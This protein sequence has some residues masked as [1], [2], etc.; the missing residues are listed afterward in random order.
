LT[1]AIDSTRG[2]SVNSLQRRCVVDIAAARAVLARYMLP[3][4]PEQA[5]I[6]NAFGRTLAQ[7]LASDAS[8]PPRDEA[9]KTGYAVIASDTACATRESPRRLS[10][11]STASTFSK[12]IEPGTV[13]PVREGEPLPEGADA[14]VATADCYRP[15]QGPEVLVFIETEPGANVVPAGSRLPAGEVLLRQGCVVGPVEMEILAMLGR[16][17]VAVRRKP[18][19]GVLTTGAGV[20]D[21][22]EDVKPG[23]SRNAARYALIGMLLDS[24]CDLGRLIHVRECRVGLERALA[25]CAGCDAVIVALASNDKHD[26]ALEALS[27]VGTR[28]FDRVQ[29]APGGACAFGIACDTPVFIIDSA[30]V[31]EVFEAIVRP[32]LM[33]MLGREPIDRPRLRA[34]LN[35]TL[36]LNPGYAHFIRAHTLFE[37]QRCVAKPV[38]TQSA[39]TN[40]LIV[41]EQNVEI[42]KRGEGVDVILL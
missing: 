9:A 40:S 7:D 3:V 28:C 17:G 15:E 23:Q 32:G 16:H 35:S 14:V 2:S 1:P 4:E 38:T 22:L 5:G 19:I 39:E 30:S 41:V 6:I 11:L 10:V 26:A 24:G 27:S 33:M 31:I 42:A 20:V 34:A 21:I 25:Q 12:R 29:I 13:M 8:V 37:P 18:R 36:R